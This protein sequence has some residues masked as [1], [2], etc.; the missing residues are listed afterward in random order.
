MSH[1]QLL[2]LGLS[3]EAIRHR[4]ARGRLHPKAR[5]VYA[6]GR[7]ELSRWG[8]LM[9]G[10]LT[11]RGVVA[12]SHDTG[13]E[14]WGVR[15][16]EVGPIHL[17]VP[18][19][20]PHRRRNVIVHRRRVLTPDRIAVRHGIP[21]TALPLTLIDVAAQG[22]SERQLEA[23]INQTDALD[24]LDPPALRAELAA[25]AGQPG[26]ARLR[27]LLDRHTFRLTDSELERMFLRLVRRAGLP[28]PQTQR[29]A[30]G[31]RVDFIW[32]GLGLVVETDSLR[33]HRTPAQ[34]NR[35]YERDH[36]HRLAGLWPLRFTH[37]QIARLPRHVLR[38]LRAEVLRLRLSS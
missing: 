30:S 36:A 27:E 19:T 11:S 20:A 3:A 34:Q 5:G 6:V 14:L 16:R 26:V 35:D 7:P 13:T 1:R 37:F 2:D 4:I 32:P 38:T 31:W 17:S 33:Y 10:V 25:L 28:E 24:L 29:Y 12:V 22:M 18:G 8:E 15:R 23:A 9:V 21:V